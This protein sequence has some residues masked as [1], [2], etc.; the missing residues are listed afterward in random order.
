MDRILSRKLSLMLLIFLA[1]CNLPQAASNGIPVS[2]GE[3][4]RTWFDAPLNGMS[5]P[6]APYPVVIHSYDRGGVSQVEFSVNGTVLANLNPKTE[7][8]LTQAEYEWKPD[9]AGNF[10][11]RARSMGA[12]GVFNSEAMVNVTILDFTPTLV[13]SFTP[14]PGTVTYTPTRVPSFT[15]TQVPSFTPTSVPEK[16][17]TFQ[18][19]LST[20]QVCGNNSF[21]IQAYASDTTN[22]KGITIF[23]KMKDQ[24]GGGSAK[25]SEGD[26]MNPAG[27]GWYTYTISPSSIPGY[28]D[29]SSSWIL[30]QLVAIGSG[31]A[32]EGR[33]QVYSDISQSGCSAAPDVITPVRPPVLVIPPLLRAP[34]KITAPIIK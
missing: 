25:W 26:S 28:G 16:G 13:P 12:G 33:S 23:M 27:N 34:T 18:V 11:L 4:G 31:N 24:G 22:V 17:L 6:P 2:G 20:T 9:K 15:P 5:L 7:A 10:I 32:I 21:T 19:N 29:Y 30:Y 14:T 8:G 1:A 3:G